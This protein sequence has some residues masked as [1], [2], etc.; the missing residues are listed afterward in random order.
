MRKIN[1]ILSQTDD[2]PKK[3][4]DY[5]Q[6]NQLAKQ[7]NAHFILQ[8][9]WLAAAPTIVG[10]NS[11]ASNLSNGQLIVLADSA[12]VANKIKLTQASL[13]TQLQNLQISN[14]AFRECKVTAIV[15]KVQVKSRP[16]PVIRA[17]RLLSNHASNSLRQLAEDLLAKNKGDSP[18]ATKLKLLANK[19]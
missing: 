9:C 12:I 2:N 11:F 5:S 4:Y 14:H 3:S 6:F 18:L 16:K 1:F 7:A 13:L 17:P 19:N 8:Q 10:E 15:V